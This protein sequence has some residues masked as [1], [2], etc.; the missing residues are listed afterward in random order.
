MKADYKSLTGT[1]WKPT[2]TS[3]VS[4]T[5]N[6]DK[7]KCEEESIEK[8]DALQ[9]VVSQT[10]ATGDIDLEN[11]LITKVN[12]QGDKVRNLKVNKAPKVKLKQMNY[13]CSLILCVRM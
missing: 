5:K 3:A 1:D 2:L 6:D 12:E 13:F 4:N 7:D 10:N 11:V 9:E 8:A